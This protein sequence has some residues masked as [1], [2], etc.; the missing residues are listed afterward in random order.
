MH[1]H[2][3]NLIAPMQVGQVVGHCVLVAVDQHLHDGV[4]LDVSDDA[5]GSDQVDFIDAH[6]FGGFKP[7]LSLQLVHVIVEDIADH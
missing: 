4:V 7:E 3:L 2:V 5:T 6:P 1:D